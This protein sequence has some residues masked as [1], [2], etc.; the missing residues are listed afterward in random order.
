M[1]Y[2]SEFSDAKFKAQFECRVGMNG[3]GDNIKLAWLA[4][5]VVATF[6]AF[7]LPAM[8]F[9]QTAHLAA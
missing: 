8:A 3:N 5:D 1:L 7:K 6:N 4:V 2:A 9:Q